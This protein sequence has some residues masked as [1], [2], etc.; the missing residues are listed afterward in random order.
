M[1]CPK[2]ADKLAV[3]GFGLGL[4]AVAW[5]LLVAGSL[6]PRWTRP[7]NASVTDPSPNPNA[8]LGPNT[9]PRPSNTPSA[10]GGG[11]SDPNADVVGKSSTNFDANI[12]FSLWGRQNCY[13]VICSTTYRREY[14]ET[15]K[16]HWEGPPGNQ[17]K[18]VTTEYKEEVVPVQKCVEANHCNT[19]WFT[20]KDATDTPSL[21]VVSRAFI[22]PSIFCGFMTVVLYIVKLVLLI[23]QPS[24]KR[25]YI[26]AAYLTF[27]SISGACAGISVGIF[28]SMLEREVYELMWAPVLCG[29]GGGLFLLMAVSGYLSWRNNSPSLYEDW[30]NRSEFSDGT[31]NVY[32]FTSRDKREKGRGKSG[33]LRSDQ[34]SQ[35]AKSEFV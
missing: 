10:G 9:N 1:A 20:H 12:T 8:R 32:S 11:A 26:R 27:A 30:D 34:H 28:V 15:K 6:L 5:S 3:T 31:S 24:S 21:I 14:S 4:A 19:T 22:I 13:G 18:V 33:Y 25:I 29:V 23:V 17:K 7:L 35:S 16:W 2:N